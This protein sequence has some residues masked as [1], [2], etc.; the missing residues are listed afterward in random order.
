MIRF[1]TIRG[2]WIGC[3]LVI[4]AGGC[5]KKSPRPHEPSESDGVPNIHE[6][7][8]VDVEEKLAPPLEEP[9]R[10]APAVEPESPAPAAAVSA[11]PRA[12]A[13]RPAA[14]P[15]PAP[16]PV[17]VAQ[18]TRPNPLR[19][20]FDKS[21]VLAV[22]EDQPR[23]E[24]PQPRTP[25]PK[26]KPAAPKAPA[27]KDDKKQ[28]ATDPGTQEV[29]K[30]VLNFARAVETS[31]GKL[32]MENIAYTP[33]QA[34][35]VK[36]MWAMI[37]ET[38]GFEKDMKKA[39]GQKGVEALKKNQQLRVGASVPSLENIEKNMAVKITGNQARATIVGQNTPMTLVRKNGKWKVQL[40]KPNEMQGPAAKMMVMMFSGITQGVK[41]ARAKIGKP[42]YTPEKIMQEVS[43]SMMPGPGMM[44]GGMKR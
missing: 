1:W 11:P 31:N 41:K 39:Y 13:P 33:A 35:A 15:P 30:A 44:P 43:K 14:T 5:N 36:A 37:S 10:A 34:P 21:D 27:A 23:G 20:A 42:G 40:F 12:A 25:A 18:P 28:T 7:L 19:A 29:L 17:A 4:L 8:V 16:K 22:A 26:A 3:L 24:T 6:V 32:F 9:E 2:V 38:N